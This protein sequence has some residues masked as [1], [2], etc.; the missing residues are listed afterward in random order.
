MVCVFSFFGLI[1]KWKGLKLSERYVKVVY[2]SVFYRCIRWSDIE[3]IELMKT[4]QTAQVL[5]E[6]I[7]C[8]A[9]PK[10]MLRFALY[11]FRHPIKLVCISLNEEKVE[12]Q[13]K[14]I[15][16][17]HPICTRQTY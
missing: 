2:C 16:R 1:S 3:R 7:G 17:F 8:P 13:L 5:I 11:K 15:E 14:I 12:E 4:S 10:G 9:Y 6:L